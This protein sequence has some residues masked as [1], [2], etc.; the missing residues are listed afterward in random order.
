MSALI[1]M[2]GK[3]FGRLVAVRRVANGACGKAAWEC[4]CD[5]GC[6]IIALAGNLSSATTQSCGCLKRE[7][8][9]R[10]GH[11]R[12]RN[13]SAEYRAW[14]NIRSRCSN[15]RSK[16]W[17]RYGGRGIRVC[18]RWDESFEAFLADMGGRPSR[19]HSLDRINNDGDY[20]PG[21]C[22]WSL[23][24]EQG[25]NRHNNRIYELNGVALIE[26]EWC[27]RLGLK[28]PSAISGRIKTGWTLAQA[29]ATP[30]G[31]RRHA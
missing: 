18:A 17:P 10:H 21:N 28:S 6:V 20:E 30:K 7:Q 8:Q 15:Q 4:K 11:A 12:K 23:P 14:H 22:R 2:T 31:V 9:T 13:A 16:D 25:R 3:R 27:R 1:D 26:S 19:S 24:L 29:L 5:C